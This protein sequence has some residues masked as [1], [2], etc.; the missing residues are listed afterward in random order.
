MTRIGEH[1]ESTGSGV[2]HLVECARNAVV[3]RAVA[4]RYVQELD[5]WARPGPPVRRRVP[6]LAA[7]LAPVVVLALWW[8]SGPA[9]EPTA[10]VQ[11]GA[12][13]AIVSAPGTL[14]RVVRADEGGTEIAVDRGAVTARLWRSRAPHRL[15]LSGG[16]VTATA[17]GTV[18]S[19]AIAA[20]GPVVSV[21]EGSVEVRV[22]G[23]LHVIAAGAS[24]PETGRAADPGAAYAL[25]ALPAPVAPP[26]LPPA[27]AAD[28][29]EPDGSASPP[30]AAE[31]P[32][33]K[34]PVTP[35]PAAPSGAASDPTALKERWH[36]ARLLRGQGRFAA[37]LAEC[38]AIADTHDP[39]WSAIALVEA[40]RIELGPLADPERAIA[41]A[42]R[43]IRE[44]PA[45]MLV[46]EARE[47]RC[48]ALQQLGRAGECAPA[49]QP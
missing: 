28:T 31:G 47:L 15:V 2:D 49:T 14:Y 7:G 45:D 17:T 36:T 42:D 40:V 13:V 24:W 41:I 48:R 9:L 35:H 27:D 32:A 3:N 19:L 33:E 38:I 34:P 46:P 30:G 4:E 39:M 18:Y 20:T 6:W 8:R 25:L 37:A 44:W 11:I 22:A 16:G 12:R 5:R 10:P 26:P 21:T 43:M 1:S 29:V 23:G